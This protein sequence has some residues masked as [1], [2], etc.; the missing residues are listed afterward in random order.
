MERQS[1]PRRAASWAAAVGQG[2]LGVWM[3]GVIAAAFAWAP[4]AA[5]FG[6]ESSRIVFFHVPQAMIAFLAFLISTG[7]GVAYLRTRRLR[8]DSAAAAVAAL[9][10]LFC[11]LTTVTGSIFA[12]VNWGTYWNWDP[13][14]TTIV[15]VLFIYG[16]YFALRSGVDDPERRAALASA[17]GLFAFATVPFLFFI[18]P[19][20]T[21]SLHPSD[22]LAPGGPRMD[23][24][25]LRV[26]LASVAGHMALFCWITRL[27][28]R[29]VDLEEAILEPE[30][31][32]DA[33]C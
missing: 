32:R 11:V 24:R 33:G 29:L 21:V 17:Y 19:R 6:G 1:Q 14:E 9:G 28:L 30:G 25:T 13:R 20:L 12:R 16:A 10:L 5:G 15:M 31:A 3:A 27:R 7:Y 18:L 22:T 2:A 4:R 26:F 23:P 8:H